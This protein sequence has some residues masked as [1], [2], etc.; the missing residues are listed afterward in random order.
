ME[1]NEET[2]RISLKAIYSV[3]NLQV[4]YDVF[5]FVNSDKKNLLFRLE[6]SNGVVKPAEF[7]YIGAYNLSEFDVVEAGWPDRPFWKYK[8]LSDR[9]TFDGLK[10]IVRSNVK[11]GDSLAVVPL[12]SERASSEIGSNVTLSGIIVEIKCF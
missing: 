12:V 5:H 4:I 10:E 9:Q 8:R 6:E 1:V 11:Y 2:E 7:E 3:Y